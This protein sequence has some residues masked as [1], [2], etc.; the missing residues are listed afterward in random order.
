MM[1]ITLVKI[2]RCV[3]RIP[4]VAAGRFLEPIFNTGQILAFAMSVI[5]LMIVLRTATPQERDVQAEQW[6][7]AVQ[8][9]GYALMGWAIISLISAPFI[10]IRK[11]R[12]NGK[13]DGHRFIYHN[14]ILVLTKRV[15]ADIGNTT[16]IPFSFPDAEPNSF[17]S[18]VVEATPPANGRVR[19]YFFGGTP[20]SPIA[21]GPS[22]PGLFDATARPGAHCGLRLPHNR[23]ATLC[24]RLE[25][26]TVPIVLRVFCHSFFVGKDEVGFA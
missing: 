12:L 1:R 21:I 23:S 7:V 9:F 3:K 11:D 5:V 13:W 14:R 6:A 26:E 8:A 15:E 22:V 24:V 17:V 18:F 4:R 19:F 2:L 25:L 16:I 20:R 10:V